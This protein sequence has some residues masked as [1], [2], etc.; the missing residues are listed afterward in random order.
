MTTKLVK[1][2]NNMHKFIIL[3]R[4]SG[5]R[6]RLS[7]RRTVA[8]ARYWETGWESSRKMSFRRKKCKLAFC[9]P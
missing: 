6:L 9:C 8:V 5:R 2:R 4:L 3:L 1:Q 7:G